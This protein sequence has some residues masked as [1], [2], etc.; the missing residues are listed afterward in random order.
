MTGMDY[1]SIRYRHYMT[2]AFA[3]EM[4]GISRFTLS[5]YE[6][7]RVKIPLTVSIKLNKLYNIDELE[8]E[9]YIKR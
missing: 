4:I 9:G 5:G 8:F 2:Q 6:S 7:N 3:A 1:K